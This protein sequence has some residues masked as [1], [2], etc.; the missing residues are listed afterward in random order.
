MLLFLNMENLTK[1]KSLLMKTLLVLAI[2][3]SVYFITKVVTEVRGYGFIGGDKAVTNTISFDGKGEV[4]ASPD[5][6]N[7]S[8]T[9]KSTE[10]DLKVA[11]GKVTEK[12]AKVLKFLE[13]QKID[14]KDIKTESYNSYPKYEWHNSVC[15]Q[16]YSAEVSSDMPT[17][18]SPKYCPSGKNVF[19]GYEVSENITVKVRDVSKAGDVLQGLGDLG[20]SDMSGPNFAI[21]KEDALKEQARKMAIDEAKEKAEKLSKDLGVKLVRI[22]SFSENGGGYAMPMYYDKEMSIRTSGAAPA[23]E[24]PTGENKIISNVTI[25]YEIR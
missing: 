17:L 14:K 5:I 8:F 1:E 16:T 20:V 6:A 2:I 4:S 11:Q 19:V 3:L 25:T 7:I 12:E 13:E 9:L 24:L 22:V 23:P 15:P 18:I 21:D 10:K